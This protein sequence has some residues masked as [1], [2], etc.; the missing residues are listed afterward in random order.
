MGLVAELPQNGGPGCMQ[1]QTESVFADDLATLLDRNSDQ[2]V[3]KFVD[4][5]VASGFGIGALVE[6]G[7]LDQ[8][9][10]EA[11]GTIDADANTQFNI[12]GV[13]SGD[14]V[15]SN[16]NFDNE[17]YAVGHLDRPVDYKPPCGRGPQDKILIDYTNQN[18]AALRPPNQTGNYEFL[19]LRVLA[20]SFVDLRDYENEIQNKGIS[21]RSSKLSS[22][23]YLQKTVVPAKGD[24]HNI[25]LQQAVSQL[26]RFQSHTS[27]EIA[28]DG[29]WFSGSLADDENSTSL[30]NYMKALLKESGDV[31]REESLQAIKPAQEYFN[32]DLF[33]GINVLQA[34][35]EQETTR[36][37]IPNKSIRPLFISGVNGQMSF[38]KSELTAGDRLVDGQSRLITNQPD[39]FQKGVS[40]GDH[41]PNNNYSDATV[42]G[43]V[44][45]N[46]DINSQNN[47]NTGDGKHYASAALKDAGGNFNNTDPD[48]AGFSGKAGGATM[49]D[50]TRTNIETKSGDITSVRFILPADLSHHSAGIKKTVYI[51][52]MPEHLGTIRL[53][54][55]SLNDVITGRMIV[56]NSR[57]VTALESHID[58][59]IND[60]ADKGIKLDTFQIAL[61]GGQTGQNQSRGRLNTNFK[62]DSEWAVNRASGTG[63]NLPAQ[64]MSANCRQYVGAAGVNLLI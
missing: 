48:S 63:N 1:G 54:L 58:T 6:I 8:L 35:I 26:S 45:G 55:S 46:V 64:G 62:R 9:Q 25:N 21:D 3:D 38:L 59:L 56:D 29:K 61:A 53:T 47:N 42:S 14:A 32:K 2:Q 60:L 57:A 19:K 11:S 31:G 40:S 51:K 33:R 36:E 4:F 15:L 22:D 10:P 30:M 41:N 18:K 5:N 27:G 50:T 52:M 17:N 7:L 13:V 44:R 28:Q 23:S 34:K 49:I 12:G 39:Q 43:D 20:E 16:I 37:A 24:D